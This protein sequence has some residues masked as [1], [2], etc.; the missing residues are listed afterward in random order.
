M[1]S[2]LRPRSWPARPS[3]RSERSSIRPVGSSPSRPTSGPGRPPVGCARWPTRPARWPRAVRTRPVRWP[4]ISA[5]SK[6]RVSAFADRLE[7]NGPQ[8]LLDDVTDFARRRPIVFLSAAVGVGFM[9]GRLARA[10]RAVQQDRHRRLRRHRQGAYTRPADGAASTVA[11]AR[12]SARHD[13]AVTDE[14]HPDVRPVDPTQTSRGIAGRTAVGDD[15]RPQHPAAQGGRTGQDRSPRRDRP[16]RQGRGDA[17]S[18]R[19]GR[20][21][22]PADAVARRSP[23]C[24]IRASTR[25]CRS[26]SSGSPGPSPPPSC[27]ATGKRRLG[28]L[29]TL[30]QTKE[31][32]KEDVEW[33]KAQT[34]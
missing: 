32:I 18:R 7:T 30:P 13:G 1:K 21:A 4:A 24:S 16:G 27:V 23:G 25:R 12:R 17:R 29:Q 11:A 26:P 5:T 6:A 8:G 20:L 33:A 14:C 9:V 3:D 28:D 34:S 2:R 15:D 10:G 31:T 19:P 22:G